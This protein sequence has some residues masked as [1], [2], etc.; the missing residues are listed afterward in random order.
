MKKKCHIVYDVCN[1]ERTTDAKLTNEIR[2]A[3]EVKRLKILFIN[4]IDKKKKENKYSKNNLIESD[5]ICT[6]N[7]KIV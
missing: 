3:T 2:L 7:S 4:I 6:P 1:K 5:K